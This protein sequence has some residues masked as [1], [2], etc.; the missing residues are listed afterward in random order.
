MTTPH[1]SRCTKHSSSNLFR[2]L[3]S[4]DPIP[5]CKEKPQDIRSSHHC[6]NMS[7]RLNES[8]NTRCIQ[9]D[10]RNWPVLS[11]ALFGALH[12]ST[13]AIVVALEFSSSERMV[14]N[15]TLDF[16]LSSLKDSQPLRAIDYW[17]LR[18]MDLKTPTSY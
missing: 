14:V 6:H 8:H 15:I 12:S 9:G 5:D 10:G 1:I 3:L 17:R 4:R 2:Y 7:S 16:C 18:T 13:L 11:S